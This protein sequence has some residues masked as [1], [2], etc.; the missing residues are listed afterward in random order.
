MSKP[1]IQS[2]LNMTYKHNSLIK[3]WPQVLVLR[4]PPTSDMEII[5]FT[6]K[7]K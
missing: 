6:N 7:I 1:I 4:Q 5:F 2:L 3:F